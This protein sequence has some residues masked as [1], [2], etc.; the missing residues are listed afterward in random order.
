MTT[1]EEGHFQKVAVVNRCFGSLLLNSSKRGFR[2][3][4]KDIAKNA[5]L[6]QP[7]LGVTVAAFRL[8]ALVNAVNVFPCPNLL[9]KGSRAESE[10][11]VVRF[12][13]IDVCFIEVD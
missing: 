11:N 3:N 1:F 8:V 7:I 4:I 9:M 10:M 12:Q 13:V 6:L 5:N 2:R